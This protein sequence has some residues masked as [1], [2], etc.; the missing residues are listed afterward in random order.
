MQYKMW[1]RVGALL[2]SGAMVFTTP[3]IGALA[4]EMVPIEL[5]KGSAEAEEMTELTVVEAE[6]EKEAVISFEAATEEASEEAATEG[7]TEGVEESLPEE[8][9]SEVVVSEE[10]QIIGD[11]AVLEM[12]LQGALLQV[13]NSNSDWGQWNHEDEKYLVDRSF[14]IRKEQ[15]ANNT[16]EDELEIELLSVTAD[17]DGVEITE[18]AEEWILKGTKL[19]TYTITVTYQDKQQRY[20]AKTTTFKLDVVDTIYILGLKSDSEKEQI[21]KEE[22]QT[23]SALVWKEGN[24]GAEQIEDYTIQWTVKADEGVVTYTSDAKSITLCGKAAGEVYVVA[25]ILIDGKAVGVENTYDF[26]VK[27]SYYMVSM[28]GYGVKNSFELQ[29][30]Q[31]E[32]ITIDP[33]LMKFDSKNMQGLKFTGDVSYQWSNWNKDDL[34]IKDADDKILDPDGVNTGKAPFTLTKKSTNWT[35][36]YLEAVIKSSENEEGEVAV[37]ANVYVEWKQLELKYKGLTEEYSLVTFDDQ[38]VT[39]EADTTEFPKSEWEMQWQ[40]VYLDQN[41]GEI[42]AYD[43]EA[44]PSGMLTANAEKVTIHMAEVLKWQKNVIG[45]IGLQGVLKLKDKDVEI[46]SNHFWIYPREKYVYYSPWF[47]DKTEV[48][49]NATYYYENGKI[50][51]DITDEKHPD[52]ARGMAQILEINSSDPSVFKVEQGEYGISV[53]AVKE[54]RATVTLKINGPNGEETLSK[55]VNVVNHLYETYLAKSIF[56]QGE[57]CAIEP[58]LWLV[59]AQSNGESATYEKVTSGYTVSYSDYNTNLFTID[60]KGVLTAGNNVDESDLTVTVVIQTKDGSTKTIVEK[61]QVYITDFWSEMHVKNKELLSKDFY[62]GSSLSIKDLGAVVLEH[63]A[64]HPEGI[65]VASDIR[66]TETDTNCASISADGKTL[67]IHSNI[68]E[69]PTDCPVTVSVVVDGMNSMGTRYILTIKEKHTKHSLKAGKVISP[70]T[71]VKEEQREYV[72][73]CGYRTVVSVKNSMLKRKYTLTAAS[74]TLKTNQT[75]SGFKISGLA[76]GDSIKSIKLSSEKYAKLSNVDLKKGTFTIKALKKKGNATLYITLASPGKAI[77]VPVKV[78]T[79]TVK[80]SKVTLSKNSLTLK[81]GASTVLTPAKEPFTSTEKISYTTSNKKVVKVTSQS[82][83]KSVKL[84]AVAPGTAKIT[85]K[86]GKRKAE[87]VVTVPGIGN[88]KSSVTVK[89]KKATVLKPKLYGIKG[90]VTY[91]SSNPAVATIDAKGKVTGV[92]KGTTI[93]TMKAGGYTATC[94]V[95]VK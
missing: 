70:A 76:K 58:V 3:S 57:R 75:V 14:A 20:D 5:E 85:A 63:T 87:C 27:D 79:S 17:G 91:T 47:N 48:L 69:L 93:I 31:T 6:E 15:I 13:S 71:A 62:P 46:G 50:S 9:A 52:G 29:T 2:L 23:I 12:E 66:F 40:F 64:E 59:S 19:G 30:F 8:A 51:Y 68:S 10:E 60:E 32:S 54:G 4:E 90:N 73:D 21:C 77:S 81:K 39:V 43:P 44:I 67:N 49:I 45:N 55:T 22:T 38:D 89:R 1:K 84:T 18:E 65:E 36:A 42:E 74:I 7:S 78:Q 53:Q 94:K 72:C 82:G 26:E 88:V 33:E 83:G 37:R 11:E 24:T 56:C 61:T 86:S 80:T 28:M 35:D 95:K 34:V 16:F 41:T 25:E 92:K